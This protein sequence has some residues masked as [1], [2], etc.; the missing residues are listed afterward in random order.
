M[1]NSPHLEDTDDNMPD[2]AVEIMSEIW[3][4]IP[5][6]ADGTVEPQEYLIALVEFESR[7]LKELFPGI[8]KIL[9]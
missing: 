5:K 9:Q 1:L 7:V 2:W 6:K 4:K 3:T 8:P